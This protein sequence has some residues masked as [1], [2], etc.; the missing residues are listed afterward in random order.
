MNGSRR[1]GLA[2]SLLLLAGISSATAAPETQISQ[3]M[4]DPSV[5]GQFEPPVVTTPLMR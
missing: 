1:L 2:V 5:M 4:V 3:T